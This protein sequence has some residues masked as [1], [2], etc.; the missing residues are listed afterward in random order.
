MYDTS[1]SVSAMASRA[2]SITITIFTGAQETRRFSL[3]N[4]KL[5]TS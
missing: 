3:E 1:Q 5:L 4:R 2:P